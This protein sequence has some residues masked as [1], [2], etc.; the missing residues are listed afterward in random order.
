[1]RP[2]SGGEPLLA[3]GAVA[4][5]FQDPVAV[6]VVEE[7][8]RASLAAVVLT[9]FGAL[10]ALAARG[11]A[12]LD[13]RVDAD[14]VLAYE[15]RVAHVAARAAVQAVARPVVALPREVDLAAEVV[16]GLRASAGVAAAAHAIL[17]ARRRRLVAH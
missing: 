15:A 8:A 14:R 16:G 5:A 13:T 7:Q 6:A 9:P 12:A 10:F 4:D 11:A 17:A 3:A 2:A 1:M